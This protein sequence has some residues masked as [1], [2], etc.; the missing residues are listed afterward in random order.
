[1]NG[2]KNTGAETQDQITLSVTLATDEVRER[3]LRNAMKAVDALKPAMITI[4]PVG[5][6]ILEN[7][8][9]NDAARRVHGL[10]VKWLKS[11]EDEDVKRPKHIQTYDGIPH[12]W[13][14][15]DT[16]RPSGVRD[17]V[18]V[19][20]GDIHGKIVDDVVMA[21]SV[22]WEKPNTPKFAVGQ[23]V[24]SED[25]YRNCT[26]LRVDGHSALLHIDGACGE[27][28]RD[29]ALLK[30][31]VRGRPKGSRNHS[32]AT[33]LSSTCKRG[34]GRPKG[35]KNKKHGLSIMRRRG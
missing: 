31:V 27:V 10:F 35:S 21:T 33:P 34:R 18:G 11:Y 29:T 14:Y 9:K 32:V 12:A 23:R 17:I 16:G 13:V 20:M 19:L 22:D 30:L 1:M 2:A 26:I 28:Y 5:A 24:R 7:P 3:A 25:I 8:P 4:K 6:L 15:C